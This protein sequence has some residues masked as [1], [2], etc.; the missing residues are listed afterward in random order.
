MITELE[1]VWKE[2]VMASFDILPWYLPGGGTEKSNRNHA[3]IVGL[4]AD[5]NQGPHVYNAGVLFMN[6][7]PFIQPKVLLLS[8]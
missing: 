3:G 8:N 7:L 5:L 1:R 4:W 6:L 2:L